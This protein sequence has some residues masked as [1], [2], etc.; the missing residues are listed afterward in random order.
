MESV[1]GGQTRP[2]QFSRE[3]QANSSPISKYYAS[4]V[5]GKTGLTP[6]ESPRV[7]PGRIKRPIVSYIPEF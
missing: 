1:G 3:T 2:Q 5:K 4:T 7:I 6:L